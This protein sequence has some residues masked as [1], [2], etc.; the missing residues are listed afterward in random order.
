LR[1]QIRLAE[2][3]ERQCR[4]QLQKTTAIESELQGLLSGRLES[5]AVLSKALEKLKTAESEYDQGIRHAE[6][7]KRLKDSEERLS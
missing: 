4:E 3:D 7:C 6:A 5:E 1:E 2:E